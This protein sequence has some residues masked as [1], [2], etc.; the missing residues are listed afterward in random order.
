MTKTTEDAAARRRGALA[1]PALL[2]VSLAWLAAAPAAIAQDG[3]AN[4]RVSEAVAEISAPDVDPYDPASPAGAV[5]SFIDR[6]REGDYAGAAEFLNLERIAAGQ[7]EEEGARMARLLKIVLDRRLWIEYAKLSDRPEGNLDDGLPPH[8]ESIGKL[9]GTDV[10]ILLER[11]T[12]EDGSQIWKF[13]SGTVARVPDLQ[14]EYGYGGLAEFLPAW[15]IEIQFLELRLWQWAGLMLLVV[16][17][18]IVGWI[19]TTIL[20]WI[21]RPLVTRTR[22]ELDDEIL[23]LILPP[24][25]LLLGLAAFHLGSFVLRFAAPVHEFLGNLLR[26]IAVVA[27]TWMALR[28]VDVVSALV[29]ERMETQGRLAAKAALPLGRRTVKVFL[30]ALALIGLLDNLGFNVTGLIAGLGVGGLAFALAAQK[31]IEN[32]FGGV[33][34]ITDQP[35]RVGDFCRYG[36]DKLGTVEEIGMRSTRIRTLDRTLVSVPNSRF[37]E[38]ELENFAMRDRLRLFA[39]LGLRYE[40]TPEQ[41]RHVLTELRKV[42]IAHPMVSNDPARVRFSGFGAHSLDVEIFAYVLTTDHGEFTKVREDLY[43]RIMDVVE[44]SGTGFAFPSQTLYMARDGGLDDELARR[45]EQQ[46][47]AWR[48]AGE[49]PF[50]DFAE[51]TVARLDGSADWPPRGSVAAAE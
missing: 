44:A 49:L 35:I 24:L 21:V 19:A 38:I 42:L 36:G 15:L 8:L 14:R 17:A 9:E 10:E 45:A 39:T 31:T 16:A 30:I 4:D 3:Q 50:P 23:Q 46:V 12:A 27:L 5:R 26:G 51:E 41:L 40:T 34:L 7:R 28:V 25:R 32:L 6:S 22:T 18:W 43:L 1:A 47:A 48:E 13:A 11:V 20:V 37:S 29:G 33:T 2:I